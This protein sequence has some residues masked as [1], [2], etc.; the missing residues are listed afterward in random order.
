[1]PYPVTRIPH[2]PIVTRDGINLSAAVFLPDAPGDGPFPAILDCVPYRKDDDFLWSDWDTYGF[3]ASR[4]I[5]SVR[6]DV[7][8]TGSS[9]GIAEDE[10]TVK[11]LDDCEDAI[12]AIA[13]MDWCT[14]RVGMTGVSWGGFNTVQVA[15][16]RPEALG[17]IVP[18][19]WAADRYATDVHYVGGTMQ[20]R[21][22]VNWQGGMVVE[23]AMPPHPDVAG[24]RL[25]EWWLERLEQTPQWPLG[26]P[27]HQRRDAYWKHGSV[28]E[29][30]DALDC[31]VLAI[32]G[33]HDGYRDACLALLEHASVPRRA[34]I[35]PWGHSRPNR[36]WPDPKV[37]HR[38]L[39][40]R[41]FKRWLADERNGIDEEPMLVAFMFDGVPGEPYP[42][43][44][45]AGRW[46]A[47]RQWPADA[48]SETLELGDERV[49]GEAPLSRRVEWNGRP[50]SV[51]VS[52]PWWCG[53]LGPG[54][55]SADMRPDDAGSLVWT[56]PLLAER[57][58]ILGNAVV[59]LSVSADAEVA[60]VAARLE[61]VSS[62][63]RSALIARGGL[64]LTRR[65]SMEDPQ[66]LTPG[67][68]Y[69]VELPLMGCGMIVPA[70]HRLRLAVSGA[71]FPIM[72]P[73]PSPVTLSIHDGSIELPS[74][75]SSEE[76]AEPDLPEP[77]RGPVNPIATEDT[78]PP[79]WTIERDHVAGRV[80]TATGHGSEFVGPDG[81]VLSAGSAHMWAEILDGDPTSCRSVSRNTA[82]VR[83]GDLDV[84]ARST[85]SVSCTETH[86]VTDLELSV[87]RDGQPLFERRW[88]EEVPRDLM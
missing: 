53:G 7:R 39:M 52:M 67:R 36:G 58:E 11:E 17:A 15:M 56:T 87:E 59:R 64:N 28:C 37:D 32:G 62:D 3:M 16:R 46:R 8:G 12:A 71:D 57:V 4:G 45:V 83:H 22:S 61:H 38:V 50:Q 55:F 34:V 51:G 20:V 80:R 47:W 14:G 78:E 6:L 82:A 54:G 48:G 18:I 44:P 63:G 29:D 65:D 25:E 43:D 19:H 10:Y 35:G 66:A 73:P 23:N 60:L 1:V 84:S 74:P 68:V 5:A 13:A 70:G 40:E 81:Q 26:W 21:E 27:R 31:P 75:P 79:Y 30:W 88:H 85:L 77:Q 33:W 49:L 24:D 86:F 9:E 41:W 42:S 69:G 2:L 72:W 76:V